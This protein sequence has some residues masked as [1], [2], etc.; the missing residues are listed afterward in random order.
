MATRQRVAD[1]SPATR[2]AVEPSAVVLAGIDES[3]TLLEP[4]QRARQLRL[5]QAQDRDDFLAARVLTQRLVVQASGYPADEVRFSQHCD[6]CG[7]PDGRPLIEGSSGLH[8]SWSHA[9]GWVAAVVSEQPC[10]IDVEPVSDRGPLFNVLTLEEQQEVRS[11]SAG[12]AQSR[13]FLRLWVRKEALVK[14]A[15]TGLSEPAALARLDVRDDDVTY[16][17][18]HWHLTD[19]TTPSDVVAAIAVRSS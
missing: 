19:L 5:R 2:W 9:A 14:A 11:V 12:S 8:I 6:H 15:G 3:P 17:G 16:A 4:E 10:G 18:Q 13:A 1:V 7:G